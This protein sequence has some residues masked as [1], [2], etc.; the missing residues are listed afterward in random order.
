MDTGV[1]TVVRS[2]VLSCR[3][4][5]DRKFSIIESL[6]S[7]FFDIVNSRLFDD[8]TESF[9]GLG[10]SERVNVEDFRFGVIS[11]SRTVS[12]EVRSDELGSRKLE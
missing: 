4:R 8:G 3:S 12:L 1:S 9:S 10:V 2:S 5:R 11:R 7:C 6:V